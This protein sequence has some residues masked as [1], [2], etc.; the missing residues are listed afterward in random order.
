MVV[1]TMT[2][3]AIARWVAKQGLPPRAGWLFRFQLFGSGNP[4]FH[5]F[6]KAYAIVREFD[7]YHIADGDEG[8]II[9]Q[10]IAAKNHCVAPLRKICELLET[11]EEMMIFSF[12]L[13]R[14]WM[15]WGIDNGSDAGEGSPLAIGHD[16]SKKADKIRANIRQKTQE[17]VG[18]VNELSGLG[19]VHW[20]ARSQSEVY[21]AWLQGAVDMQSNSLSGSIREWADW[22]AYDASD[23]VLAQKFQAFV[24]E[25][26]AHYGT[27][28]PLPMLESL[29]LA[30]GQQVCNGFGN[31]S[32]YR[33]SMRNPR[34]KSVGDSWSVAFFVRGFASLLTRMVDDAVLPEKIRALP[35]ADFDRLVVAAFPYINCDEGF[36]SKSYIRSDWSQK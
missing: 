8:E 19:G 26:A 12:C 32:R 16:R 4:D 35:L 36:G 7:A 30:Y 29:L 27:A 6:L 20:P 34:L 15:L 11:D 21:S 25:A 17:I 24:D 18:L 2:D 1:V 28:F 5:N 14:A 31:N 33:E 9:N 13:R 22:V 10:F 23:G 3:P